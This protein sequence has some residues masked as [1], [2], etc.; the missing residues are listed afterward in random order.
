M[1]FT[2]DF[3]GK[4]GA[5]YRYWNLIDITAA[6]I[7]AVSGNYVFAKLLADNTYLP[8]YFGQADNLQARIPSHERW[9][10]AVRLGA[11]H[12]LAHSTLTGEPAR[13]AEERDLIQYWNP[14]LNVQHRQIG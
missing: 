11:T 3:I 2:V 6:G 5:T 4:S 10:E 13:L 8:L 14:P 1:E 9:P 12:V 7:Q